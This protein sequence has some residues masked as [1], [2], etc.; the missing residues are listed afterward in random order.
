M[1]AEKLLTRTGNFPPYNF[2]ISSLN[3][4]RNKTPYQNILLPRPDNS[5]GIATGFYSR[6]RQDIFLYAT[7]SRPTLGVHPP[8]Y[9]MGTKTL[10]RGVMRL[11]RETNYSLPHIAKAKNGEDIPPIPHTSSW[12]ND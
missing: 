3:I 6:Q 10:S 12:R 2:Y 11:E 7:A 8:S 5:I 9:P 4:I 1:G